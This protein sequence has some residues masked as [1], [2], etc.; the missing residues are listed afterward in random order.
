MAVEIRSSDDRP[1]ERERK[2]ELYVLLGSRLVI[3][4]DPSGETLTAIDR[5]GRRTFTRSE[6]FVHE[7]LTGVRI[8]LEPFFARVNR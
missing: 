2:I 6:V 5:D 7:A 4:V 1:G 3:D 8:D